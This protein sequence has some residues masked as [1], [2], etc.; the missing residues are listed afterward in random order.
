MVLRP[1]NTVRRSLK[2]VYR[3]L[4]TKRRQR[5]AVFMVRLLCIIGFLFVKKYLSLT[6]VAVVCCCR[7]QL[8]IFE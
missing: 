5:G 7:L 8:I 4:K 1:L 3:S 6:R 2:T